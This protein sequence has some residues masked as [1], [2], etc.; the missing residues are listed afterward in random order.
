MAVKKKP[1]LIVPKSYAAADALLREHGEVSRKLDQADTRLAAAVARIK[2]RIETTVAPLK[3]RLQTIEGQLEAYADQ[4]RA[5]LTEGGRVKFHDMP[6]GRIGWR[7]K[8]PSV[9]WARGLDAEIIVQHVHV[10]CRNLERARDYKSVHQAETFIRTVTEPNKEAML[11]LPE[12]ALK[13]EGVRI[14]S[15]G[16]KF[17]IEAAGASLAKAA[18]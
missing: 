5:A 13:V 17:Y 11:A 4:E 14:G 16:E 8:P 2:V 3:D 7:D 1:E 15:A 12:L 10:L 6:A 9:K 18:P